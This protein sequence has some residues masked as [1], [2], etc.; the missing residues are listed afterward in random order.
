LLSLFSE[1]SDQDTLAPY[2]DTLI[3][4]LLALLQRG[5]RRV[6]EAALTAIAALADTAEVGAGGAGRWWVLRRV[7]SMMVGA[8]A[9]C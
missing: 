2:L 9:G 3:S 7:V 6:Q 4:K 1:A 8:G 5:R